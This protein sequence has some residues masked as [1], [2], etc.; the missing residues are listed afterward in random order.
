MEDRYYLRIEGDT[1]GFTVEG[2]HD[3]KEADIKIAQE[4]YDKFFK[5]QSEGKQFR[6]KEM[7]AGTGLF[8]YIEE[9]I[10]EVI[11]DNIPTVEDRIKALEMVLLEVL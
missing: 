1:F 6:L 11:V 7:P 9:Y 5:L 4:E 3:I 10:P 2:I 8:D